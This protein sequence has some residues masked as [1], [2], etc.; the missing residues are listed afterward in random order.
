MSDDYQK[1]KT[2]DIKGL[3][4]KLTCSESPEQYDVLNGD[5]QVAYVRLRH[6]WL[7]VS[8]PSMDDI[9]WQI[10]DT[11]DVEVRLQGDGIFENASER[12]YFLNKIA[13]VVLERGGL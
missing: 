8:D 6:G 1:P 9:W 13:D 3:T 5:T 11:D 7:Y 10:D 12:K 4:F 2:L